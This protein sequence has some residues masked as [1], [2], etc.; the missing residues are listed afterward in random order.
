MPVEVHCFGEAGLYQTPLDASAL[1]DKYLWTDKLSDTC[2]NGVALESFSFQ[3][4]DPSFSGADI[5]STTPLSE[6][7]CTSTNFRVCAQNS[8]G[9]STSVL[10][11]QVL[12][13]VP[14]ATAERFV[15][16]TGQTFDVAVTLN[17]VDGSS[18]APQTVTNVLV[19]EDGLSRTAPVPLFQTLPKVADSMRT[20]FNVPST[21]TATENSLPQAIAILQPP[22]YASGSFSLDDLANFIDFSDITAGSIV[23]D[24]TFVHSPQVDSTS[25][26]DVNGSLYTLPQAITDALSESALHGNGVSIPAQPCSVANAVVQCD[27]G[28]VQTG[29]ETTLDVQ[30]SVAAAQGGYT[31]AY[32]SGY[33]STQAT[34]SSSP[35][36][37]T[38]SQSLMFYL[39]MLD[40]AWAILYGNV[41]P[42]TL[43]MSYG[44]PLGCTAGP[45]ASFSQFVPTLDRYWQALGAIGISVLASSGAYARKRLG[46]FT[47]SATCFRGLL[48]SIDAFCPH[49]NGKITMWWLLLDALRR[50]AI[51]FLNTTNVMQR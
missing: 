26:A 51:E 36:L 5:T 31:Y 45:L 25:I 40:I 48:F 18:T 7:M 19:S 42:W 12:C 22:L 9:E 6:A 37:E 11:P 30:M 39:L 8:N 21:S 33:W 50:T 32:H 17:F 23:H 27:C 44:L 29:G 46:I 24:T 2:A 43:S 49:P 28:T 13:L 4:T 38:A 10:Y 41:Q 3:L 1:E 15:F 35:T 34:S 20:Y 16:S 14:V 47:C